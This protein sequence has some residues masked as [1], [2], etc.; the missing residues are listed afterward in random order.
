MN[1]VFG[2]RGEKYLQQMIADQLNCQW[3]NK[4]KTKDG[5]TVNEPV[6]HCLQPIQFYSYAVPKEY[7]NQVFTS[8][9]FHEAP[10]YNNT[11][12]QKM[13]FTGMRKAMGLKP[14]PEFEKSP[15]NKLLPLPEN[16]MQFM[17]IFP[18]GIKEDV[19][20]VDDDG[21]TKEMI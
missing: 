5:K 14:I 10:R 13:A 19:M 9:K 4:P 8:L 12:K 2:I 20:A 11:L 18:I 21:F 17:H 1:I 3:F 16:I 7:A 15:D 6:S